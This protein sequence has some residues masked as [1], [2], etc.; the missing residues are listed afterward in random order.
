MSAPSSCGRV[1]VVSAD[2]LVGQTR[3]REPRSCLVMN[4]GPVEISFPRSGR[5]PYEPVLSQQHD[6]EITLQIGLLID[7]ERDLAG[8]DGS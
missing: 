3:V 5:T 6:R 8:A 1:R 7:G 4:T 2:A